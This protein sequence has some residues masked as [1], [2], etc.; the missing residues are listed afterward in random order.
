MLLL[1][2][3]IVNITVI[4]EVLGEPNNG[5][6]VAGLNLI[7]YLKQKGHHVKVV[8]PDIDKKDT[9]DYYIL[10]RLNL[11]PICNK[12][13][14]NN[15]VVLPR[16]DRRVIY[17]AV[18]DADVVH[19]MLP[20]LISRKTSQLV[21][22]LGIPM[23][24]GFHAMAES[25][26]THFYLTGSRLANKLAY[27][28]Y[29]KNLYSRVD[30][31]HYPTEFIRDTFERAV[32]RH[33]NA[34]V[35]SNGV[36]QCFQPRTVPKPTQYADKFCI[37]YIGRLSSEKSHKVLIKA[38]SKSKYADQIQL[39][40][41]G[42]GPMKDQLISYARKC[43]IAVP[44]IDFYTH[45]DLATLINMCDLY[46][47]PA[48]I[49]IEAISCLEAISCGLVPLISD[50]PCSATKNFAL[51]ERNIFHAGDAR[52]LA[53]K[54]DYFFERPDVRLDM[55]RRYL[56]IRARYERERCMAQMEQMLIDT[57]NAKKT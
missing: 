11:G 47:H 41:A 57:A 27:A 18:K 51:D 9:P 8:C 4:C 13:I 48:T 25:L 29:D 3:Y 43:K 34:Y 31:V 42:A 49:E 16:Y 35:I 46:C 21:R 28:W 24:A 56:G 45:E 44:M 23:T 1:R 54:I 53:S 10:P 6:T 14:A 15:N 30:A 20:L 36:S 2:E 40:F 5:T 32:R 12:I 26:T 39:F 33:T 55:S 22:S 17:E 7:N 19:I 37:L 50:S 52:D 38:V